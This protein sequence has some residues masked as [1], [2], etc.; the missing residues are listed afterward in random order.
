MK[1]VFKD[2]WS[3]ESVTYYDKENTP[4][5][6]MASDFDIKEEELDGV[7]IIYAIY[8]TGN[9][10][11]DA[12][13]LFEKDEKFFEVHGGHCSCYGLEGQWKPEEVSFTE[14]KH[15]LTEGTFGKTTEYNP[16]TDKYEQVDEFAEEL[17]QLIE[18]I[19][20]S[21]VGFK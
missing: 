15:R 9:Y 2:N 10:E 20:N 16:I 6:E 3:Q 5:K 12:F 7:N 17:L 18:T 19:E 1:T 11:G 14:I 13:V 21:D 4:L 8:N